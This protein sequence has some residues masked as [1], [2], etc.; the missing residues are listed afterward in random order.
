MLLCCGDKH[1]AVPQKRIA[2]STA[3]LARGEGTQPCPAEGPKGTELL[4]FIALG[5][6]RV[7]QPVLS[8]DLTLFGT[9]SAAQHKAGTEG[10]VK[11][12]FVLV[13]HEVNQPKSLRTAGMNSKAPEGW[14][15]TFWGAAPNTFK[16]FAQKTQ[17][18]GGPGTLLKHTG[19]NISFP[20]E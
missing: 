2:E 5:A 11:V 19:V 10:Q 15:S 3:R 14:G 17:Q 18:T 9:N 8:K 6:Q 20:L 4:E 1:T 16:A 7:W 13:E 12:N